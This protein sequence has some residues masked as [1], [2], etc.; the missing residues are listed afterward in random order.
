MQPEFCHQIRFVHYS[1]RPKIAAI[2]IHTP[3][4][5]KAKR[6]PCGYIPSHLIVF[7]ILT[8]YIPH[9][10]I[11]ALVDTPPI[12]RTTRDNTPISVLQVA[13][14][15]R[16]AN[17]TRAL[18]AR[19]VLLVREDEQRGVTQFFFVEH[20][21]EFFGGGG[22]AVDVGAV[23]DEDYGGRVG[24]VAAP[25]GA[26]GGLTAEVLGELVCGLWGDCVRLDGGLFG[27]RNVRSWEGV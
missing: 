22:Q 23:D 27:K 18:G 19:L 26:D 12:H 9:Q 10:P 25:V 8:V 6:P 20:G 13:E 17:L 5:P 3:N 16:L 7:L 1:L 11:H 15:Q 4:T 21:S 14:L 2:H 24:V